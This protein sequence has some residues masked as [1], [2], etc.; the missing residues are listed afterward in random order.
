[1]NRPVSDKA[2]RNSRLKL[3]L[4]A[5]IFAAPMLAAGLLS[6][7]GWQPGTKGHGEPI[8]PQRNFAT[9]ALKIPLNDGSDYAWRDEQPRMTLVVLTG[10]ACATQCLDQLEAV[11]KARV[12]L[13]RNQPRLRLLLVGALPAGQ[14][15]TG[16]RLQLGANPDASYL[17]GHDPDARLAAFAPTVADGVSAVLVE[18]NGTALSFYPAGFDAAG[19]AQDLQKVIR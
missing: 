15:V 5:A 2:L 17:V 14:S 10:S 8:L 19:L 6:L 16:N 1:M 11:A 9:E 12:M 18:S 3:L 4:I 13:N 7:S